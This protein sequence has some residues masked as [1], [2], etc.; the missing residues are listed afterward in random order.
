[1]AL[2]GVR[3]VGLGALNGRQP[4]AFGVFDHADDLDVIGAGKSY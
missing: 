2:L 4:G 3:P 1:V